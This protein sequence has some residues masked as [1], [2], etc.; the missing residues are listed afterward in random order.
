MPST[1]IGAVRT[2]IL[3][4]RGISLRD[5][6][7]PSGTDPEILKKYPLLGQPESPGFEI[8]G[9]LFEIWGEDGDKEWLLPAPA[10]WFTGSFAEHEDGEEADVV[11][12]DEL[13]DS[14]ASLRLCGNVPRPVWILNPGRQDMKTLSGYWVNPSAFTTMRGGK[15]KIAVHNSVKNIKSNRPSMVGLSAIFNNETRIGIALETGMRR[16]IAGH[17]YSTTQIR[18]QPGVFMVAGL[19]ENLVQTYLDKQGI[20]TIGGEQRI[21]RYELLSEGPTLPTGDSH[22]LMALS[23]FPYADLKNFGEELPRVSGPLIRMGG[24]DMKKGFHKPMTSYFPAGTV[25]CTG[26]ESSIPFGFIRS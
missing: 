3:Q 18:L 13:P 24:W 22:W 25:I 7:S 10:N 11:M 15:G 21:V 20:F 12:A 2:A 6:T 23:T 19:S 1:I 16:V 26:K 9:P 14:V 4:Q 5:Y 8:E 17:L